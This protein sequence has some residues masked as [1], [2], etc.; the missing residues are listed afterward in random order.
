MKKASKVL[1]TSLFMFKE[2]SDFFRVADATQFNPNYLASF[3]A[4]IYQDNASLLFDLCDDLR[5]VT[6]R[7]GLHKHFV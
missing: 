2:F 6:A 4:N 5:V 7:D 3:Q 1:F